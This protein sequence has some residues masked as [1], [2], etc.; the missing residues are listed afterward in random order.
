MPLD[1][2]FPFTLP[3][4]FEAP[5]FR[6]FFHF[7]WDF[8]IAGFDCTYVP[9]NPASGR[10]WWLERSILLKT[11]FAAK[12]CTAIKGPIPC[13]LLSFQKTSIQLNSKNNGPALLSVAI[14]GKKLRQRLQVLMLC[15]QNHKKNIIMVSALWW[16][17]LSSSSQLYT[18]ILCM[19]KHTKYHRNIAPLKRLFSPVYTSPDKLLNGKNVHR[20][21]FR[22]HGTRGPKQ[23][24]ERQTFLQCVTEF[25][26]FRVNGLYR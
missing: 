9:R 16:N 5:L 7:P 18:S 24:F 13:Y 12:D 21:A 4:Y 25:A 6:T 15:G 11:H 10:T 17:L 22:L 8:E 3:G 20:S 1:L 19:G 14:D 26:Q 2:P 23:I